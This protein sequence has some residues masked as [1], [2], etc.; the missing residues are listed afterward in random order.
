MESVQQRLCLPVLSSVPVSNPAR[1]VNCLWAACI[2]VCWGV[3]VS[4]EYSRIVGG[5]R[6]DLTSTASWTPLFWIFGLL[7]GMIGAAF[8]VPLVVKHRSL[9][10]VIALLFGT[11]I[12][13]ELAWLSPCLGL[14]APLAALVVMSLAIM[15]FGRRSRDPAKPSHASHASQ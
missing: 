3:I 1:S 12:L 2:A 7:Q 10:R 8:T 5:G 15:C 14:W 13:V 9:G 6:I 4:T 11:A